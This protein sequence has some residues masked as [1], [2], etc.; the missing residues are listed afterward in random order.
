MTVSQQNAKINEAIPSP[1]V[2]G[3]IVYSQCWEDPESGR[4]ALKITPDDDVLVITSGGCNVLAFSLEHPRSL[5]AIDSNSA[6]NHL[7]ELKMAAIR[8]LNYDSFLR[9]LGVRQS[10][11]RWVLYQT[12]RH[13]LPTA[14][15]G[16]WDSQREKIE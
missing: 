15:Q 9:F 11:E 12:I 8:G 3:T 2:P 5:I 13:H 6:Q 16:Y 10:D 7:L 14:A 1:L 4:K